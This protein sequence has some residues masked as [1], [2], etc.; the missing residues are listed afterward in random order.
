MK[1]IRLDITES[2]IYKVNNLN[3]DVTWKQRIGTTEEGGP[4][5]K[6]SEMRI[7]YKD[8]Y[9]QTIKD[10]EDVNN[11]NNVYFYFYDYNMD[12]YL[13]FKVPRSCGKS[14]YFKFY[15]YNPKTNQFEYHKEWDWLRI[16]AMNKK[17]KQILKPADGH[18]YGEEK[19]YQVKDNKL[20]LI[21]Q[22]K[23]LQ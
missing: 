7:S 16:R 6:I 14:C 20:I 10:I 15:L 5:S 4:A 11:I 22:T 1:E 12:G 2:G 8:R 3:F 19:L 9:L 17:T 21:K 18:A 23:I 13:D